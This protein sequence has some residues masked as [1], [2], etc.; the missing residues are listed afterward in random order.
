MDYYLNEIDRSIRIKDPF[1]LC[2]GV[3]LLDFGHFFREPTEIIILK[4]L[5][6]R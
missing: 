1:W 2:F 5:I 6:W 3:F 4:R